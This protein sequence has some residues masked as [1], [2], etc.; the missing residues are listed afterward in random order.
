MSKT[1]S[2]WK[3]LLIYLTKR[4]SLSYIDIRY[5]LCK[6]IDDILKTTKYQIQTG[7]QV[8]WVCIQWRDLQTASL[9][10]CP[11]VNRYL[12]QY[13]AL[14]SISTSLSRNVDNISIYPQSVSSSVDNIYC[15]PDNCWCAGPR[16]EWRW[17]SAQ[18][19]AYLGLYRN[20]PH[21]LDNYFE[22]R[23]VELGFFIIRELSQNKI[24]CILKHSGET[25]V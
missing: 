22:G 12:R 15:P 21:I 13:L 17:C 4:I 24:A 20:L 6:Y 7:V 2:Q 16:P 18:E 3:I 1:P 11:S 8:W 19:P 10:R 25:L 14:S 23:Q 9:S 5:S